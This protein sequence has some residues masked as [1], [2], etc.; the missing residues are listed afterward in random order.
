ME[1]DAVVTPQS[2]RQAAGDLGEDWA[3][4]PTSVL[5]DVGDHEEV[6][7]GSVMLIGAMLSGEAQVH[8]VELAEAHD[9]EEEHGVEFHVLAL[10]LDDCLCF[11][12]GFHHLFVVETFVREECVLD[13]R[14]HVDVFSVR[15][16]FD[17]DDL[18]CHLGLFGMGER[19]LRGK[20]L[21]C[22]VFEN[23]PSGGSSRCLPRWEEDG[24]RAW[25]RL[26]WRLGNG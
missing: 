3:V 8:A 7:G 20:I 22:Q 10:D 18:G 1:E 5:G 14:V 4:E 6:H 25:P 13:M 23:P 19:Y 2:E 21:L 24:W 11:A 9:V 15:M 17:L 12:Q 16:S 26:S